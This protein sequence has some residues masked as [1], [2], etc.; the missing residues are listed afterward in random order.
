MRTASVRLACPRCNGPVYV[1]GDSHMERVDCMECG[2]RLTTSRP[3]EHGDVQLRQWTRRIDMERKATHHHGEDTEQWAFV[4][5]I[6]DE[7]SAATNHNGQEMLMGALLVVEE[8]ADRTLHPRQVICAAID[9][10]RDRRATIDAEQRR[11]ESALR[12]VGREHRPNPNWQAQVKRALG[13]DD[14]G[15]S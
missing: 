9:Q 11:I 1:P 3:Q 13:L 14:G 15:G 2:A 5:R 6:I 12:Q 8:I 7:L 10:L 4:D